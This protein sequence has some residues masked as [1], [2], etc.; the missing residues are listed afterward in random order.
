LVVD[1]LEDEL[2]DELS[3]DVDELL[4]S[5]LEPAPSPAADVDAL[6]EDDVEDRLSVL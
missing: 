5:V 1:A 4:L 2:L 6:F 3:D